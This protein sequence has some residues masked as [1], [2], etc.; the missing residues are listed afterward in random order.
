MILKSINKSTNP[1]PK[2]ESELAA[3]MDIRC[4]I[5]EAVTVHFR[6]IGQDPE[7]HDVTYENCQA[8]ERTQVIMDI[9]N[10]E[11]TSIIAPADGIVQLV[12]DGMFLSG[13][14]V[15]IGHGQNV[16]TS[17]IHLSQINVKEGQKVKKGEEIGRIGMTGRATG[18]HLHW[19]VSW[20]N[21]RVDPSVFLKNSEKFCPVQAEKQKEVTHEKK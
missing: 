6:Y 7:V 18:P 9:A 21:I 2:Y 16:V 20:K 10:K 13:K 17:Y 4:N 8:R 5:A 14:T 19:V 1:L 12:H 15:L 3:G 11:G